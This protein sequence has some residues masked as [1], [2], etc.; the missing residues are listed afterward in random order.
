EGSTYGE[1]D[2]KIE[3]IGMR[4][5]PL[6]KIHRRS[7]SEVLEA[8][9]KKRH[10]NIYRQLWVVGEDGYKHVGKDAVLTVWLGQ[11]LKKLERQLMS[12]FD[13]ERIDTLLARAEADV[14]CL[15]VAERIKVTKYL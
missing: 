1:V 3:S 12:A 7:W 11:G 8:F 15:T 13:E 5:G 9:S 2:A 14:H 6:H 10:P 4:L